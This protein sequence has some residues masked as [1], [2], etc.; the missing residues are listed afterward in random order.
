MSSSINKR[1]SGNASIVWNYFVYDETKNIVHCRECREQYCVTMETQVLRGNGSP[2]SP[3]PS[4]PNIYGLI[5]SYKS[6]QNPDRSPDR[7]EFTRETD[8]RSRG[9]AGQ[10][11][12]GIRT[13][14][15]AGRPEPAGIPDPTRTRGYGSGKLF[16]GSGRVGSGRVGSGR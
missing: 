6:N 9:G 3:N 16:H 12:P 5:D 15:L 7:T 8:V 14:R 1:G 4:S 11:D 13:K 10:G 2:Y